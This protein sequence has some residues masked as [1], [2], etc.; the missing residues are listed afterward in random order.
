MGRYLAKRIFK[1]LITIFF[2]VTITFFIVRCMPSNPADLLVDPMLGPEAVEAMK[3]SLGL[4]DH[5]LVQY[6]NYLKDLASGDLGNSFRTGLPVTDVIGARL[7]W[8]IVLLIAVQVLTIGV[9]IP[10]GILAAKKKN[11]LFDKIS[12]VFTTIG[13]SMFI[14]FLS[15]A[16]LFIFAYLIKLFPTG[17]AYTPPM[18]KGI[19]FYLDVGKHLVL[20]AI[21]LFVT[22]VAS[23]ILYTR[24]STLDVLNEDYIRTAY[25]KGWNGGYILRK[26]A[27]KNAMIPTVTVIGLNIGHMVGGAIMTETI[28]AWPGIGRLIY[29]SVTTLD[30]PVLQGAFLVL[31]IAVV[32]M[33]II[34]DLVIAWMDPRIKLEG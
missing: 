7:K 1:G 6:G 9:G 25:A 23:V 24:N 22:N 33:N 18:K 8:T 4:N 20:P 17:G 28:F 31:A 32:T 11:K 29:E 15:F 30:Y 26:H 34:T 13:I 14:P 12:S 19:D 2:S 5:I 16:F 21:T 10:V 27:L 3:E